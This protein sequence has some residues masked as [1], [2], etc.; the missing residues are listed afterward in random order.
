[1]PLV[2]NSINKTILYIVHIGKQIYS[3]IIVFEKNTFKVMLNGFGVVRIVSKQNLIKIADTQQSFFMN[4]EN[5]IIGIYLYF[6][7]NE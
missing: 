2:I 1:M 4:L 5:H 6:I 7:T 3:N